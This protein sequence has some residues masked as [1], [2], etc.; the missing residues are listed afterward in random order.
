[1]AKRVGPGRPRKYSV[2]RNIYLIWHKIRDRCCNPRCAQ[3]KDYG[4][5][6]ILMSAEWLA[7][8]DQFGADMGPRPTPQHSTER[9]DNDGNYEASNCKWATRTEQA[10]NRRQARNAKLITWRGETRTETEWARKLNVHPS[11]I[12]MR[13]CRYGWSIEEALSLPLQQGKAPC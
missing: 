9:I 5:R 13:L 2:S 3:Y 12:S 4:A 10:N 7:G 1:M 8:P 11:V 6:G